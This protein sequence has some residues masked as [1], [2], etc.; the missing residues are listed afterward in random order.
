[1][2]SK[3][4]IDWGESG[5]SIREIA[6]YGERRAAEIGPEN[7]YNFAIGNPSIDPPDCVHAAVERLLRTVPP[8]Q[9]HAYAPAPGMASVREKVAAYL[10][11]TFGEAYRAQ[12]IYMT[13]GASSAL[14]ILTRALMGPGDEAIVFAPYFPEYAVYAEAAGGSVRVV[15]CRADTFALDLEALAAAV[16]E[17]TALLILNSP[18]NPSG[19]VV[20]R[21]ELE[22]LAA[23][24]REKQAR[25]GHPIYIIADEPYRELVY[26][27]VEVPFLP[28]I[29]PNAIYCYSYSKTLSLPGERV[30]FLALHPA[31]DDYAAVH[32]AVLG[33][34]RALGYIC[35]SSLFQLAVAECLGQTADISAYAANRELIYGALTD[36]G[37]ACARPDGAFYLFLKSPEPDARAFCR[38]A[39]DYDILLVPGDDFGCP[40]YARLASMAGWRCRSCQQFTRTR[41]TAIPTARRC[42]CP[43]SAWAFSPC[44]RPWT[45]TPPCTRPCSARGARWGISVCR[46]CSS[47]PWRSASAR[48]RTSR[49][50][51]PTANL[52]TARSRTWAMRARGRTARFIFSSSRRSRTPGRFAAARWTMTFCSCRATI[53]AAPVM[54]AW[55]TAWRAASSSA[56]SRRSGSWLRATGFPSK[57]S[58]QKAAPPSLRGRRFCVDGVRRTWHW[59]SYSHR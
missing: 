35:V 19:V 2:I 45:I 9:L 43:A 29:Y 21:P 40:G 56:R 49:P 25:Y 3:Q 14:A 26:G 39:M 37:Y 28:A 52:S 5:C 48:R 1:M 32:A 59:C 16:T 57:F 36:M 51:R 42:L 53:S 15:P 11:Q 34:G 24:L 7:V 30:G 12:D 33:A 46:R 10:T 27:G 18:N 20:S 8:T 41:S 55:P 23:L 44:T 6:A 47:S 38:R 22:A 50:M 13:D 31:M 58:R 4:M 54:R 17:K